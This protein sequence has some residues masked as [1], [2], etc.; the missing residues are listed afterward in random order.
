[1]TCQQFS[2]VPQNN[3]RNTDEAHSRGPM[4]GEILGRRSQKRE[5]EKGHPEADHQ[6]LC[7]QELPYGMAEGS[8]RKAS[9][10]HEY[11]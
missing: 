4:V 10:H 1:V 3:Y 6:A 5:V 8:Q 2:L 7:Q 11:S 9:R